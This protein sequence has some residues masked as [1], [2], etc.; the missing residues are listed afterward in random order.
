MQPVECYLGQRTASQQPEPSLRL[1]VCCMRVQSVK[2]VFMVMPAGLQ[3]VVNVML[4]IVVARL[5]MD[6]HQKYP[7]RVP[8]VVKWLGYIITPDGAS[9]ADLQSYSC[10]G[11]LSGQSGSNQCM[12]M[13]L[14]PH[15]MPSNPKQWVML[16]TV[17]QGAENAMSYL[18]LNLREAGCRQRRCS[19]GQ[20]LSCQCG[21]RS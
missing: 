15:S 1:Q 3:R 18:L 20:C 4:C 21:P 11:L 5:V 17:Q 19:P 16:Q 9:H 14:L 13:A 7:L 10:P 2:P 8:N 12:N 6:H